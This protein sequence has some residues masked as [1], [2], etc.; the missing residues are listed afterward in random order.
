MALLKFAADQ[1]PPD[2]LLD[3]RLFAAISCA[4]CCCPTL[5]ATLRTSFFVSRGSAAGGLLGWAA[6]AAAKG[7]VAGLYAVLV[8]GS[9]AINYSALIPP[10]EAKLAWACFSGGVVAAL[11]DS[12]GGNG[13]GAPP[14]SEHFALELALAA[15]AGAAAACVA[16]ALS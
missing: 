3:G 6:V 15:V 14:A 10:V 9:I 13:H 12:S 8:A 4:I 7:S 16:H 11:E 5:G 2:G 1:D